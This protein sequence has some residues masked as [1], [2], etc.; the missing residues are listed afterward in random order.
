MAPN[1]FENHI[2]KQLEDREMRPS[3]DAWL[4]LS[5]RLDETAIE[6]PK[7][8]NY[9][10]YAV[11]ACVVGLIILSSVFFN[12]TPI[13]SESNIQV[14]EDDKEVFEKVDDF[15]ETKTQRNAVV[16]VS[17]EGVVEE[18][19]ENKVVKTKVEVL[20]K[21]ALTE[22]LVAMSNEVQVPLK[23]ASE[24]IIN[25]KLLQVL[26]QVDALEYDNEELTDAE[27]D[28]LLRR[29]QEEILIDK[30]FREN[31]SIDAMALL[32]EVESELDKSFRDQIFESLKSGFFKVRTAVADR[33]N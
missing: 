16:V 4:K 8:R 19:L 5:N 1:K 2:K 25:T 24:E 26:A 12:A 21:D 20:E 27:V 23:D 11:A 3:S 10:W 32:S 31:H 30:L 29:A 22:T 18:K 13:L 6:Q 33:N 15:P 9:F 17:T 7:R 14:V 28:S